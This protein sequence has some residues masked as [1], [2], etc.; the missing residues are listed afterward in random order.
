MHFQFSP[1]EIQGLREGATSIA[2]GGF[3][4]SPHEIL[5]R[6]RQLHDHPDLVFQFSPHEILDQSVSMGMAPR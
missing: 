4:F 6:A 2:G 3:Q 1:H 5:L